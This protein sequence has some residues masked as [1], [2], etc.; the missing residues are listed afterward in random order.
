MS[1]IVNKTINSEARQA[2]FIDIGIHDNVELKS[3]E[4]K[5]SPNNNPFLVLTFEKDGKTLTHT[6]YEPK[7]KDGNVLEDKKLNQ[8]KR[9]KHIATKFV[10]EEEFTIEAETFESFCKSIIRILKGRFE[11]KKVRIKVVYSNKN[12]T[13]FPRYVP[14]IERMDVPKSG[15]EILSIDKM[16]KDSPDKVVGDA[17]P[18][19]LD[20]TPVTEE[21][22]V[23]GV[24]ESNDLPF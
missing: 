7:D 3:I 23:D 17:N 9:L 20:L 24:D 11:G 13:A 16:T 15:L 14:F 4:Y 6:E 2:N 22:P 5:I 12:F 19:K 18:Y 1:Y 8:I 21:T 10:S